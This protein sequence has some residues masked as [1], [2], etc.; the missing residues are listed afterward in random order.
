MTV[1][2]SWFHCLLCFFFLFLSGAGERVIG[3]VYLLCLVLICLNF[4]SFTNNPSVSFSSPLIFKDLEICFLKLLKLC[5]LVI[6]SFPQSLCP[7][8]GKIFRECNFNQRMHLLLPIPSNFKAM[9]M[10]LLLV[11][12]ECHISGRTE[13]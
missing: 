5:Q 6:F 4:A 10:L 1:W 7:R 12:E 9:K 11:P 3:N 8:N 2:A 13:R